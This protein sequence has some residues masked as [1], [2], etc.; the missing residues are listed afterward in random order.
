MMGFGALLALTGIFQYAIIYF[1]RVLMKN[2]LG[3]SLIPVILKLSVKSLSR[4]LS[5]K[6]LVD[7]F[8]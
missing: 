2:V 7:H 1:N 4:F 3:V 6:P 8:K 5:R